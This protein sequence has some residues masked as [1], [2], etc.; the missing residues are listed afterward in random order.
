MKK[1]LIIN[2][3][4][5]PF[6]VI[7]FWD[8]DI[9][10]VKGVFAELGDDIN[11]DNLLEGG[12]GGRTRRLERGDVVVWLKRKPETVDSYGV[13]VHELFHAVELLFEWLPIP[14]TESSS[15]AYAYYLEYLYK[16]V[17]S[18]MAEEE[19]KQKNAE[20]EQ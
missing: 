2:G 11:L 18:F 8:C 14:L 5:Y 10:Y 9:E 12:Q 19:E 20:H 17:I 1:H 15:E 13:L 3:T 6:G 16:E 4:I 7:V